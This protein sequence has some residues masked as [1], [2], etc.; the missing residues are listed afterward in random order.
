MAYRF[1][2]PLFHFK[3]EGGGSADGGDGGSG[4][5]DGSTGSDAS[6]S[7]GDNDGTGGDD[8]GTGGDDGGD[9]ELSKARQEAAKRRIENK[10]LQDRIAELEGKDK[11]ETEKAR[12]EAKRARDEAKTLTQDN[13][14]LRVQVLATSVGIVKEAIQDAAVL[15]DWSAIEDPTDDKQLERALKALVREKPYLLGSVPG[16]SDGGAGGNGRTGSQD[17]NALLRQAAGRA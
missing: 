13:Q 11:S 17:M 6:T 9:S 2:H 1:S 3:P 16:G 12:D 5:T 14:R 4:G 7:Q 8:G 10:K 15:L